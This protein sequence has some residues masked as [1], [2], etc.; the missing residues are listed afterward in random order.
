MF[1]TSYSIIDKYLEIN[2]H[3][4]LANSMTAKGNPIEGFDVK[5]ETYIPDTN[6]AEKQ[7]LYEL[8]D[9]A[10][11]NSKV[12]KYLR[13]VYKEEGPTEFSQEFYFIAPT[14]FGCFTERN[15]EDLCTNITFKFRCRDIERLSDEP[16]DLID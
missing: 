9:K 14:L 6:A 11:L 16:V 13:I 1:T 7:D 5:I 10:L 12:S 4:I 3:R 15:S 2:E 8:L